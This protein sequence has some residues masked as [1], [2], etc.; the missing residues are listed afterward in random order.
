MIRLENITW[1]A[2]S[3]RLENVSFSVPQGRYGVL[4]GK[5]GTGKTT[6]LEIMCGLRRPQSG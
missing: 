2:P 5:T 3:F 6:L 1:H 4:M